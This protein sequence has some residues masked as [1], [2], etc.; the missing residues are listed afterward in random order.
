MLCVYTHGL[1]GMSDINISITGSTKKS[2]N[3]AVASMNFHKATTLESKKR[4]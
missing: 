1:L 4:I 3:V 2:I